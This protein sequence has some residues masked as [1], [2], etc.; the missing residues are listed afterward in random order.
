MHGWKRLKAPPLQSLPHGIERRPPPVTNRVLFFS[1]GPT[2]PW[3]RNG[4]PL[5]L[6]AGHCSTV[7]KLRQGSRKGLLHALL[8]L[9]QVVRRLVRQGEHVSLD[10]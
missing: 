4:N 3:E 5:W 8:H 7:V 9:V 2:F 6:A 1:E 10:Y